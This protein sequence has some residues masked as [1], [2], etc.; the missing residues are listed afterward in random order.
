MG[1]TAAVGSTYNYCGILNN[2][3]FQAFAEGD[4]QTALKEQV[5]TAMCYFLCIKNLLNLH[6]QCT[7]VLL[8]TNNI[9][10]TLRRSWQQFEIYKQ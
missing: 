7:S 6:I 4:H 5:R 3:L 9:V 2:R 8:S 1:V 10:L